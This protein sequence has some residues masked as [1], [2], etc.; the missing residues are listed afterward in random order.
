MKPVIGIVSRRVSDDARPW[1]PTAQGVYEPYLQA[2]QQAGGVPLIIPIFED[3]GDLSRLYEAIDGLLLAGGGDI[4]PTFYRERPDVKLDNLNINRDK[5]EL[6]LASWAVLDQKP[7]LGICRGMQIINVSLG[8]SLHQELHDV[9][10]T[11]INHNQSDA[12]K[13]LNYLVHHLMLR[14]DCRLSGI[15]NKAKNPVN[16]IHRQ[17][18]KD[19]AST[20]TPVGWADDGVIEAIESSTDHYIVGIQSHPEIM[21]SK[22]TRWQNLFDDFVLAS[23]SRVKV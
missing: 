8:G 23:K 10:E 3:S 6:T 1:R 2:V 11:K 5:V 12:E 21:V 13:D 18:I 14:D 4:H 7:L 17:A 22:H 9:Y 16:S 20:L 19:M 15:L